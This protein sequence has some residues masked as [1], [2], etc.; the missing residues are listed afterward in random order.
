MDHILIDDLRVLAVIGT[1]P[2]ERESAQPLRLDLTIGLDLADA[3]L[4][5]DLDDTVN[6]GLVVE[7][8]IDLI[9]DS[10]H[11]LLERLAGDIADV[12]LGFDRVDQVEL[13]VTKLRPPLPSNLSSVG[14]RVMRTRAQAAAPLLKSHRVLVALGSN[15]GDRE[16]YLRHAVHE[17]GTVTK[18]SQVFETDPVG[19]PDAQDA[20]LNMVVEVETSLDPHAFIR[21]CQR[22]E[23]SALRQR[24][25]HW[26]PRTLDVD[27]LFYDD[28]T[29]DSDE[30]TI[31]HPRIEERR[32]VL[33][34]LEEVA[35]ERCPA[36]WR[37]TLPPAEVIG[38]GPLAGC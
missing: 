24:V 17:L 8:I 3:S 1:L 6:Y 5:D 37:E 33:A 28:I 36:G 35:P 7:R 31:P 10:K 12:V 20:Y 9:G 2:H 19:G 13:T 23:A 30:L 21:R 18:M 38:R 11:L 14:V 22:I 26:G 27:I 29:I 16:A 25:V 4:S 15:L 32:F 34:P